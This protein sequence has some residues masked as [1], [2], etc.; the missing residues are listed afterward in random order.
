MCADQ[1][2]KKKGWASKFLELAIRNI[3]WKWYR[4][5][6]SPI[7]TQGQ[8]RVQYHLLATDICCIGRRLS[9]QGTSSA[10]ASK[11]NIGNSTPMAPQHPQVALA[12]LQFTL[13]SSKGLFRTRWN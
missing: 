8:V 6:F 10:I 13:R 7:A 1:E 12:R 5:G 3:I 2:G 9:S 4:N 11:G